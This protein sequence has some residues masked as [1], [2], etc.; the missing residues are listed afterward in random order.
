MSFEQTNLLI[1]LKNNAIR[2]KE[3]LIIK[4]N[5]SCMKLLSFLYMEGLIQSFNREKNA[6]F[7]VLRFFLG[8][9]QLRDLKLI[10]KK[11]FVNSLTYNTLC[12]IRNDRT[13]IIFSTDKGFLSLINCKIRKTGGKLLFIC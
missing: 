8:E 12:K 3:I 7:I 9:C 2:G 4:Y 1:S 6:I 11:S 5:F 13:F 10:H